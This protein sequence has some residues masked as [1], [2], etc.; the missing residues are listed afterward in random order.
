M[1]TLSVNPSIYSP[2]SAISA[3]NYLI[4]SAPSFAIL[5]ASFN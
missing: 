1:I 4:V 3:A 5:L 2:Y